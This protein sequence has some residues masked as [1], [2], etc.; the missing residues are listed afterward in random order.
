M[1][2]LSELMT[3]CFVEVDF[4]K[5]LWTCLFRTFL[6]FHNGRKLILFQP[7]LTPCSSLGITFVLLYLCCVL[8]PFNGLFSRTTWVSRHQKDK[9][10]WILMKQE[11]MGWQCRQLD[12]IQIICTVLQTDNYSSTSPL[13]F[14]QARHPSC[15][16]CIVQR[17]FCH[18]YLDFQHDKLPKSAFPNHETCW[19]HSKTVGMS[20]G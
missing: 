19:F 18:Y 17:L 20:Y 16:C 13:S 11:M 6:S 4:V 5:F 7:H 15:L 1:S 14:L 2:W 3:G 8:H 9:F 12:H 10:F